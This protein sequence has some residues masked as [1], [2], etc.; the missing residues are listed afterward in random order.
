M[1]WRVWINPFTFSRTRLKPFP[2]N[3]LNYLH[4]CKERARPQ[5]P[6][7]SFLGADLSA[8]CVPAAWGVASRGWG[9]SGL[10]VVGLEAWPGSGSLSPLSPPLSFSLSLGS[11]LSASSSEA[12]SP[13]ISFCR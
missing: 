5:L 12:V 10:Q 8:V 9:N 1:C 4:P 7:P 11:I 3:M 13:F 2:E 6:L